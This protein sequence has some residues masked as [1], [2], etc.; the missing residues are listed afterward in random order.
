MSIITSANDLAQLLMSNDKIRCICHKGEHVDQLAAFPL[1]VVAIV[2]ILL[3]TL[4]HQT[5]KLDEHER[6]KQSKSN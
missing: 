3:V 6:L 4:L 5:C 2:S 1:F